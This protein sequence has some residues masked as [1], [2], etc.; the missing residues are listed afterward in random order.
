MHVI[1]TIDDPQ[2]V[3]RI[4]THLGRLRDGR[5]PSEPPF[6]LSNGSMA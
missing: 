1:A 6:P 2:V 5:P 4:L 3:R